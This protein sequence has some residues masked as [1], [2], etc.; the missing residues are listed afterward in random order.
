M[1]PSVWQQ[2]WST[3]CF[4]MFGMQTETWSQTCPSMLG[5]VKSFCGISD[6]FLKILPFQSKFPLPHALMSCKAIYF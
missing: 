6:F 1:I 5:F 2:D 3:L 4:S